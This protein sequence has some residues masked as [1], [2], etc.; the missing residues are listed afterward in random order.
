MIFKMPSFPNSQIK[1][2]A[3]KLLGRQDIEC[4]LI[5]QGGNSC[6]Y[7]VTC[8]NGNQYALKSYPPLAP[9]M[10]SEDFVRTK[11]CV[12]GATP[13]DRLGTEFNALKFLYNQGEQRIPQPI[14]ADQ[15]NNVAIYSWL[16]GVVVDVPDEADLNEVISFLMHLKQLGHNA[17]S[18]R[19]NDASAACFSAEAVVAQF[20]YRFK[21]FDG[22]SQQSV[23]LKTFFEQNLVPAFEK[24][25]SWTV[26][27]YQQAGL[28]FSK[29][30]NHKILSPSDFGFHN[31]IRDEQQLYFIDFEY[32]GWDDPVKLVSDF[33][34]H[35]GMQLSSQFKQRFCQECLSLYQSDGEFLTRLKLLYPLYGLI[36]CLILLNE[37]K[38]NDWQRRRHAGIY[39]DKKYQQIKQQQLD[40]A[41]HQLSIILN[42]YQRF[43][44][45]Q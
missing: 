21:T 17:H 7:Q 10:L 3:T 36:W 5:N 20:S 13:R 15:L 18:S 4:Q 43:P 26:K 28:E 42:T 23:E 35:P 40:K 8:H 45:D 14:T 37:F 34:W 27:G 25:K 33:L 22:A 6:I 44:Y 2:I 12:L 39:K 41:K 30:I 31:A 1:N 16:D 38:Q 9:L 32:F 29:E 11:K 24:I 19:I